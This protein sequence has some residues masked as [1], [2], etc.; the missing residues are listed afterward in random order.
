[1]AFPFRRPSLFALL[2]LADLGCGGK[3]PEPKTALD[4]HH[5][6]EVDSYT[7]LPA[8]A[9]GVGKLD[10]N[11]LF[12]SGKTGE[13]LGHLLSSYS[14]LG[15]ESG[16]SLEANVDRLI[17]ASYQ[18]ETADVLCVAEGR[19]DEKKLDKAI[20]ELETQAKSDPAL[21]GK[22]PAVVRTPYAGRTLIT[23]AN[24]GF[25]VFDGTHLLV[26]TENAMRRAL[27][28]VRDGATPKRELP[29]AAEE[30]VI[31]SK[32]DLAVS[33][34]LEG[35]SFGRL[36]FGI[37]K[38]RLLQGLHEV[39]GT[40]SFKKKLVDPATPDA[41]SAESETDVTLVTHLVYGDES[42]ASA[43]KEEAEGLLGFTKL[44]ASLGY[45]PRLAK[46]EVS[47]KG[48]E[49]LVVLGF[50]DETLAAWLQNAPETFNLPAPKGRSAGVTGPVPGADDRK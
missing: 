36:N 37:V 13:A 39:Y 50:R 12:R 14:P 23:A 29:K 45:T 28:R 10:V 48:N 30:R 27:D 26:G 8:G 6:A 5:G 18:L 32:S 24:I 38:V 17:C 3:K 9:I 19:F 41:K 47:A 35:N 20:G 42:K 40:G 7:L 43:S 34:S 33:Y 15:P 22:A 4:E 31:A 1:M 11:A 46:Q 16:F 25:T 2:L 21:A 44:G 49:T